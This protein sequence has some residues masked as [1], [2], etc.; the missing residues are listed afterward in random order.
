MEGITFLRTNIKTNE[1]YAMNAIV[2]LVFAK[3]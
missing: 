1:P 3:Y 2:L